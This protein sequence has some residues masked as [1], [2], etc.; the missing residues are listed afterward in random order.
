MSAMD[1][2]RNCRPR[3]ALAKD[4]GEVS[5]TVTI[6]S[7][8]RSAGTMMM[9]GTSLDVRR[10]RR[11]KGRQMVEKEEEEPMVGGV[12]NAEGTRRRRNLDTETR[13]MM[14]TMMTT[15]ETTN[16]PRGQMY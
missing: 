3:L 4:L 9:N 14:M 15:A 12:T 1:L 6:L 7:S 16:T 13:T 10:K 5:G 2:A 8:T 11:I